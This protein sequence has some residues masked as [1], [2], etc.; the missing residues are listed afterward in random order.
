MQRRTFLKNTCTVCILG[1][2]GYML[3]QLAGCKTA[4]Y[5][6]YKTPQVGKTVVVPLSL[7]DG[8]ATQFIR[9]AGWYH[10]I[11]VEKKD[12]NTYQALLMECTHMENSLTPTGSGFHCSL[13]GSDFDKNGNVRKGP[14][15][16]PLTRYQTTINQNN[17]I[18]HV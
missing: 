12:G 10:D 7:F 5:S 14:A 2:A 9:P 13:H 4:S 1:T 8:S 3:P 17:L 6:V 18:I 16:M 11:A 15:A